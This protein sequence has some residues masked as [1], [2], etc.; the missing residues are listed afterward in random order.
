MGEEWRDLPL[1]KRPRCLAAQSS[2]LA[3]RQWYA[4][5]FDVTPVDGK[6]S[7]GILCLHVD[8]GLLLGSN[9]DPRFQ[10]LR[11]QIEGL[12]EDQGVEVYRGQA[13]S[14]PGSMDNSQRER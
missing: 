1:E 6:P 5:T 10:E 9:K 12:S 3:S 2:L 14:V 4:V 7:W 13:S 8:D 11:R